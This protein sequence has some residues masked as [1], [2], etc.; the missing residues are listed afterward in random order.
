M[1]AIFSLPLHNGCGERADRLPAVTKTK[2]I[3]MD[4]RI[5]IIWYLSITTMLLI[6]CGQVYWLYTQYE[7]NT[8]KWA[9]TLMQDCTSA[10]KD[11]EK[12]RTDRFDKQPKKKKNVLNMYLQIK[13]KNHSKSFTQTTYKFTYTLPG[14][15]H[16]VFTGKGLDINDGSM[17]FDRYVVYQFQP[18][19]QQLINSLLRKKGY[20]PVSHFRR[21]SKMAVRMNPQYKVTS[22]LRKSVRVTYCANP[23]LGQGV[24]FDMVVPTS[25]ILRSMAW[26]LLASLLLIVVLA[27][28][29]LYQAKTILIQKRIDGIRHEF[30][31]NMIFEMK[32]PASENTLSGAVRMGRTEFR[33]DLNELQQGNQRII[34]TSRQAEILHILAE[35]RNQIVPREVLLNAAWGDDS[36]ANS[37]ALN[38]QISYLRRALKADESLSIEVIYKKGYILNIAENA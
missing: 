4:K 16:I 7:Y 18:F 38:V 31:K 35:H 20:G 10:I 9:D 8:E 19:Q 28:C 17:I 15:K 14:N 22:G 2:P 36:Y 33:Y 1:K 21:L 32:Q 23:M 25:T 27:F 34:L 6:V 37:M 5:K 3:E 13:L 24:Q 29:L 26:Q 11:E 12:L 30:M